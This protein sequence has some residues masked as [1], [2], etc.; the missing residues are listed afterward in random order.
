MKTPVPRF[1][2]DEMLKGLGRW[3]RAAGYDT[4]ILEDGEDDAALLQRA[5][6][7]GRLLLTRDRP[8]LEYR[9]AP[10]TVILLH[11]NE[12]AECAGELSRLLDIDWQYRPFSRCMVCNTPLLTATPEQRLQ[13]PE[14]ARGDE[15]VLY[16]PQ[17]DKFYWEGS[18]VRRMRK[19][20]GRWVRG[21]FDGD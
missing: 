14:D 17:C 9:D 6:E 19:R 18:H 15:R 20:L 4:L 3:L 11:C 5:V 10:G 7:E 13:V 1:L 2:C 12:L 21:D 16:C 8:L